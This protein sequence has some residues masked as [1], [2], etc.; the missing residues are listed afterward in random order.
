[1]GDALQTLREI[2]FGASTRKDP[3]KQAMLKHWSDKMEASPHS[4]W[5]AIRG[6]TER[7]SAVELLPRITTPTLVISGT[8]DLPRPPAWSDE[9]VAHIPN[10]RLFRLERVGHSPVLE[11]PEQVIPEILRFVDTLQ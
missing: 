10:S 8:E 4:L 5:P 9:V 3:A 7:E 1:M 2:M 11:A 6:V